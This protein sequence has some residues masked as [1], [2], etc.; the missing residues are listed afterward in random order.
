MNVPLQ[1]HEIIPKQNEKIPMSQTFRD[2]SLI[3]VFTFHCFLSKAV[4]SHLINSQP[5]TNSSKSLFPSICYILRQYPKP[6][7]ILQLSKLFLK[8]ESF[9]L[10]ALNEVS[11]HIL[12]L[13]LCSHL[14]IYAYCVVNNF[15]FFSFFFSKKREN[16]CR[17]LF[18][19][20]WRFAKFLYR[21]SLNYTSSRTRFSLLT[22]FGGK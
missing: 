8:H 6:L 4:F 15:S 20:F 13:F 3:P 10:L 17:Q 5:P 2:S 11:G 22:F 7:L 12:V 14:R 9:S 16:F 21:F 19:A 18:S 1:Q